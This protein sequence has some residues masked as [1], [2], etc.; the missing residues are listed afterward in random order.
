MG[1]VSGRTSCGDLIAKVTLADV[2]EAELSAIGM[3]VVVS[4]SHT[5]ISMAGGTTVFTAMNTTPDDILLNDFCFHSGDT[6]TAL[7]DFVAEENHLNWIID[8]WPG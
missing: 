2:T 5:R 1:H 7:A 4:G 8:D 6:D 3:E